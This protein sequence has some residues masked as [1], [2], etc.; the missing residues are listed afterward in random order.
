MVVPMVAGSY[1]GFVLVMILNALI[2]NCGFVF[3]DL[4]WSEFVFVVLYPVNLCCDLVLI[5]DLMLK[6]WWLCDGMWV[7]NCGSHA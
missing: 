2:R 3:V 4:S 7:F 5:E 1:L 6:N